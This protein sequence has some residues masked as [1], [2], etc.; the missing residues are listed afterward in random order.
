MKKQIL[1]TSL[2]LSLFCVIAFAF[3][4]QEKVIQIFQNGQIIQTYNASEID[5]IEVNDLVASPEEVKASVG[6]N[7]ITITWKAV[8]GATYNV[9]RSADN[10]NYKHIAYSVKTNSYTDTEPLSGSNYYKIRALVN[11]VESAETEPVCVSTE[12][13][14]G[15][16]LGVTGFNAYMYNYPIIRLDENTVNG[17]GQFVDN[18]EKSA[19]TLLYKS[20]G[21]A[22]DKLESAS[23]P[24]DVT[25]AAIVTFT[26]GLDKGSM[27]G[28]PYDEEMEYLDGL[29]SRIMNEKVAGLN[30][31]SY[32][33]GIPGDDVLENYAMFR[34]NLEKLAS[35]PENAAELKNMAEVN[36]KFQEIAEKLT[37]SNYVQ[38]IS[39][40]IPAEANGTRVRFTFDN[41]SAASNSK[42]YV[43]GIFN[44]KDLSLEDVVYKGL[45]CTSGPI[46]K[47]SLDNIFVTFTFEGVQVEGNKLI[48]ADYV[49]EWTYIAS[50]SKWQ[51]NSEFGNDGDFET[52]VDRS[53]AVIM[54]VLDC[55]S[56]LKEEF[57]TS[58]NNAKGFINTLYKAYNNGEIPG[59]GSWVGNSEVETVTVNGVSFDMIRVD[60]G[61]FMM[62]GNQYSDEQPIHQ[63]SVSTFY[64]GKTEV[65]QALWKAVMGGNNP[66]YFR[67]DN[68]PVEQVTWNDCQTFI[69][70]LNELTGRNFRLPSEPEW[71][72][73][74]RGGNKSKGYEYSGSNSVSEVAWYGGNSGSKTH[75]VGT[76]APNELGIYDMSGNVWEWTNDK[77]CDNYNSSRNSSFRVDRGGCWNSTAGGCR[78][79]NRSR[80]DPSYCI[81]YLGL[82]L[83]F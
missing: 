57:T 63:E 12:K 69:T 26:D 36:A 19:G 47:G 74:A 53:S 23:L 13:E 49:K 10:Y 52:V 35:K 22:L 33:I 83:A 3:A 24:S 55:S 45:T 20:V 16:Y 15:V 21:D 67:G 44:I 30:I 37:S 80:N 5:Y 42:V 11:G 46:V 25:T 17:F 34:Q 65:T 38:T 58:K 81:N 32:T 2:L 8:E 79:A 6:D 60:G 61:S 72:Y 14:S 51:I 31:E 64:I 66:S 78:S 29:N 70:K 28:A 73:A 77:W 82:R 27:L 50:T 75:D 68:L 1:R 76:K 40:K 39:L 54:L 59:G 71:E 56:S 18:L 43:E 7:Q 9:Y 4:K 41:V 62:G 48:N